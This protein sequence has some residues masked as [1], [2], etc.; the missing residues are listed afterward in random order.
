MSD[1]TPT[2]IRTLVLPPVSSCADR[3]GGEEVQYLQQQGIPVQCVPGITAAAGICAEL[4]IPMTHRGVATSVRFLTGHARDGGQAMLD[5][6]IIA[7][8]DPNT[9][10]V[11]YMGLGTLPVLVEQ[12][13]QHGMPADVPAVAVERGTTADQRVVFGTLSELHD[14]IQ[15]AK[16]KSPTLLIIGQVVALAPGWQDWLEAAVAGGAGTVATAAAR[17][18]VV[19][20]C[21]RLQLPDAVSVVLQR[22]QSA[23]VGELSRR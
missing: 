19:H 10:L 16:L 5:D 4:G 18:G 2:L 7:A 22:Q 1:L 3:R 6:T 8:A 15:A 14:S 12:L 17:A 9:T 13:T 20:D 11:V 23:D 21:A